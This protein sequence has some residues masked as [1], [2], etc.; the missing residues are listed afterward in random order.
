MERKFHGLMLGCALMLSAPS[1][2]YVAAP[3]KSTLRLK[4]SAPPVQMFDVG[5]KVWLEF[6]AHQMAAIS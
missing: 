3:A 5:E 2:N 6:D 1:A 4:V